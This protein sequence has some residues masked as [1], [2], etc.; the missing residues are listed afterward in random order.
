MKKKSIAII[1]AGPGG[2]AAAMILAGK[3]HHVTVYEMKDQVGGR[4]GRFQLQG[5]TFDIGPTFFIY[6]PIL[7]E[8]FSESGLNLKDYITL[9]PLDPLYRL[10]FGDKAF[11]PSSDTSK[12]LVEIERNI[13]IT[14]IEHWQD[15]R[16]IRLTTPEKVDYAPGDV[17][18]IYPC[19]FQEEAYTTFTN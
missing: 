1:G 18:T 10:Q 4:N 17:L 16:H 5:Y 6:P 9:K 11:Y 19:N 15:V 14:P 2:L 3:G 8:V 7:E 13:R 12:M